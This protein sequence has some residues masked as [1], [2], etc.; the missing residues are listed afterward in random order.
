MVRVILKALRF[1][2]R[3]HLL[4][5]NNKYASIFQWR[6]GALKVSSF[7]IALSSV[8]DLGFGQ[9]R[10]PVRTFALQRDWPEART[11]SL[12]WDATDEETA[13]GTKVFLLLFLQ[14]KKILFSFLKK[15]F[16]FPRLAG[17]GCCRQRRTSM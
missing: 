6:F 14:K 11:G 17:A 3:H 2:R 13:P 5:Y 10:G 7:H 15:G 1:H 16:L 8:P 9:C 12:D 4:H